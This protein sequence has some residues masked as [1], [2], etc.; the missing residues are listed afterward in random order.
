M[1]LYSIFHTGGTS[2][3]WNIK[4]FFN[5]WYWE[6]W[7]G[8]CKKMKLDKLTPFTRINSEWIKD[9]NV[10]CDTIKVL[11]ENKGCKISD[12]PHSNILGI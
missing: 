6:Y 4:I 8:I 5:K 3:Q 10:S 11:A 9:L 1:S 7:T 12:I 2:I